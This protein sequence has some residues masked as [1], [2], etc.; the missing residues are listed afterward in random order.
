MKVWVNQ[1]HESWIVDRF[2]E[3]WREYNPDISTTDIFSADKI[4][5]MA[6]WTSN[7]IPNEILN[8][9]P[10]LLSCHHFVPKK[11]GGQEQ[12]DFVQRDQFI[13][14]Y[15]VPCEH[16]ANQIGRLTK[17][18]IKIIPFWLNQFIWKDLT[19][20]DDIAL[21]SKTCPAS[22]NRRQRLKKEMFGLNE[23]DFVIMSAQR[24]SEGNSIDSGEYKPKLEKGPDLFADFCLLAR[25]QL[26]FSEKRLVVLL[27]GWRRHYLIKRLEESGIKYIYKELPDFD[28][29][30]K[31]YNCADLYLCSARWEGGPQSIGEAALTRCPITST[32]VGVASQI[33]SPQ[34]IS[35]DKT[36]E[37][38]MLAQPDVE[39]AYT[40]VQEF[41][42][43]QGF[44]LFRK[45][46]EE[47]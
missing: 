9:K 6:D 38:L 8:S 28:Y 15:H 16:T 17:K 44:K 32:D 7:Q 4:W 35:K 19:S 23:D 25:E 45:V 20:L 1:P 27:G 30:N 47:L 24:D 26:K 42:I 12:W 37:S 5:V 18:P 11:F 2:A 29:L 36:A 40:K 39:Y 13:D 10:V 33:L 43:S 14:M 46:L 21:S 22:W 34:S 3:E 41:V 31:M